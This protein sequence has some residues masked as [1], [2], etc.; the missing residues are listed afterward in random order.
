MMAVTS[1]SVAYGLTLIGLPLDVLGAFLVAVEAMKIDNFLRFSRTLRAKYPRA[2][3][4]RNPLVLS[5]EFAR[6]TFGDYLIFMIFFTIAP[7]AIGLLAGVAINF[8]VLASRVYDGLGMGYQLALAV[9]VSVGA[10]AAL[11]LLV[12]SV[13]FLWDLGI[14]AVEGAVDWL[15]RRMPSGAVALLGFSSLLVGFTLQFIGTLVLVS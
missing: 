4:W 2:M 8:T 1:E 14:R 10:G 9:P 13:L 5:E 7:F 15:G 3:P 6:T 12:W 11:V